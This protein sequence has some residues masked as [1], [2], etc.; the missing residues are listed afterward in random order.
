MLITSGQ[1]KKAAKYFEDAIGTYEEH[2]DKAST[3]DD[4]EA[5]DSALDVLLLADFNATAAMI[6]YHYAGNLLAQDCWEEAKTVTNIALTL[7]ENSNMPLEDLEK[8]Q[9]CIHDI[10]LEID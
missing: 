5:D 10:W 4:S 1:A 7:A 6:H 3:L 9:Q 2:C 8:L